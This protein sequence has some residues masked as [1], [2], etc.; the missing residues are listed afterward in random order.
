MKFQTEARR[1]NKKG[2]A[3]YNLHS[4]PTFAKSDKKTCPQSLY[5]CIDINWSHWYIFVD[6]LYWQ[7]HKKGL[8]TVSRPTPGLQTYN[9][10][11]YHW[12]KNNKTVLPND[13]WHEIIVIPFSQT[14]FPGLSSSIDTRLW[15]W[16]SGWS[17]ENIGLYRLGDCYRFLWVVVLYKSILL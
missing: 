1:T 2:P 17:L 8:E 15:P 3:F 13:H 10:G 14:P 12:Q 4:D 6:L 11:R 5:P 7:Y 9:T 16:N